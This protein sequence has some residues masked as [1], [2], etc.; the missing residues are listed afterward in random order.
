MDT[1]GWPLVA[2][3]SYFLVTSTY[4]QSRSPQL[5]FRRGASP[6]V[7]SDKKKPRTRGERGF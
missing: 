3:S 7:I 1:E 5:G 2:W 4:L 6:L